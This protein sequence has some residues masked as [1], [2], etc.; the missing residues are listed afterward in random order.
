MTRVKRRG[1]ARVHAY[2]DVHKELEGRKPAACSS[3]FTLS[4]D[5]LLIH[6]KFNLN[7]SHPDGQ[8][9]MSVAL[10][11]FDC[12]AMGDVI[13]ADPVGRHDLI[14]HLDAVLLCKSARVQPEEKIQ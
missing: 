13:E 7:V 14:A 4:L 3:L 10:Q 12:I 11:D 2:T 1:L 5:S 8:H 9:D 6:L